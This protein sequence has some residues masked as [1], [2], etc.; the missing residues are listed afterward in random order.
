M[1][2]GPEDRASLP[3]QHGGAQHDD[4]RETARQ[5]GVDRLQR[6]S[7]VD[8]VVDQQHAVAETR[9][10]HRHVLGD[11][12]LP[13]EQRTVMLLG[14]ATRNL[15]AAFAPLFAI[16]GVDQRA[17]VMVAFGVLM[18]AS[19]SFGAATYYGRG[20]HALVPGPSD[21]AGAA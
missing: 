17:I 8:H 9:P 4:V 1:V 6:M 3:P 15:G 12:Q 10:G 20:T 19:F 14:M 21:G 16:P 5:L 7:R 18:Q 2:V 11:H 13:R